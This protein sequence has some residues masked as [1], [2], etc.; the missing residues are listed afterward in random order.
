MFILPVTDV[1]NYI[2]NVFYIY[3]RGIYCQ[4]ISYYLRKIFKIAV[5]DASNLIMQLV[6]KLISA[7]SLSI[8]FS[9]LLA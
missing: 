2:E 1:S 7:L 4:N 3:F 6:K 5:V 9:K 8:T